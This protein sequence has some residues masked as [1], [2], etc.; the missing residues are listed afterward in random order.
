VGGV[1]AH[2]FYF[3]FVVVVLFILK[4]KKMLKQLSGQAAQISSNCRVE[5]KIHHILSDTRLFTCSC[6][7]SQRM[8]K[9]NDFNPLVIII[10]FP[11]L[12]C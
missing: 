6:L 1:A 8:K 12:F 2:L 7:V 5:I 11:P 4:K 9:K 10:S 3:F